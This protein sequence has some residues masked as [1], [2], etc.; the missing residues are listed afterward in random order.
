MQKKRDRL[1]IIC[2]MLMSVQGK[3]GEIKKTHLMYKSNLTHKQLTIYLDDLLEKG[4]VGKESRK[5]SSYIIITQKGSHFL[6]KIREMREFES[7]FGF[8]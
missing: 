4:F 8:D 7:T 2:D 5:N 3:G 1:D 6:Q